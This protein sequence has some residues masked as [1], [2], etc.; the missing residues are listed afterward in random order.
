MKR[1]EAYEQ[2]LNGKRVAHQ[3]YDPKEYLFINNDGE[4]E[5][6]DGFTH[7]GVHNEFWYNIQN[8][9]DGWFIWGVNERQ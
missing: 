3:Y 1:S 8:W 4:F 2:M 5:T 7:G 6:E 9:Q